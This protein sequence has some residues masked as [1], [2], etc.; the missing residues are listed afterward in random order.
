MRVKTLSDLTDLSAKNGG[1]GIFHADGR[2]AVVL[3]EPKSSPKEVAHAAPPQS[4]D[5]KVPGLDQLINVVDALL[6][7][8]YSDAAEMRDAL[9][10][11]AEQKT[12]APQRTS[13]V[14]KIKR[15]GYGNMSEVVATPVGDN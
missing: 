13:T 9:K 15:D 2:P 1:S 14:F 5:V 12:A 10:R 6:R 11:I 4:V 3:R 7:A 8:Q